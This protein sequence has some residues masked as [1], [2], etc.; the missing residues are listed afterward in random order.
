MISST[1]ASAIA[2]PVSKTDHVHLSERRKPSFTDT[3]VV[4]SLCSFVIAPLV[5]PRHGQ[6]SHRVPLIR[7]APLPKSRSERDVQS[8]P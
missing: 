1:N 6:S 3:G 8:P 4:N 7:K 5:E 2:A